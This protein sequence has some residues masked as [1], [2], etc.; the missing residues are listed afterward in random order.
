MS[1][2]VMKYKGSEAMVK[3]TA[4]AGTSFTLGNT[5]QMK[6]EG[7]SVILNSNGVAFPVKLDDMA[8]IDTTITYT[9]SDAC[10]I[11]FGDLVEVV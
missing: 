6:S 5:M 9:F 8:I 3:G 11:A 2:A 1:Q 10:I 7:I 4:Y